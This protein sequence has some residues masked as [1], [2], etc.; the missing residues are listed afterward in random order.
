M[1]FLVKYRFRRGGRSG[2]PIIGVSIEFIEALRPIFDCLADGVCIADMGGRLIYANAAAGRLLG[3]MAKA[4]EE[5]TICELL[6]GEIK[7]G[8]GPSADCPLRTAGQQD[9]VTFTGTYPPSNRALRIRCLRA[10]LPHTERHFI[11]I[12]DI[13]SEA[14]LKRLEED[15]RH[16]F[17]HDLRSPLTNVMG[18]L[19]VIEEDGAGYALSPH[20]LDMIRLAVRSCARITDLLDDYLTVARLEAGALPVRLGPTDVG[21]LVRGCADEEAAAAR[22]RSLGLESSAPEGLT[23][24][25]DEKLLRRVI[26]NLTDNALK[27]T[28]PGGN[29]RIGAGVDA[30]R[31]LVRVE[32]DGP[33]ISEADLPHIFERFYQAAGHGRDVGFGLGLTFC[34]QALRAMG[35]EISAQSTVGRGSAFTLKVPQMAVVGSGSAA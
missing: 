4:A 28:P 9:A 15:W 2:A 32:D 5:R 34:R 14:D 18:V 24:L 35:G 8:H 13:S 26:L 6:C 31:I 12:E 3:S 29:V 16:M 17:A 11:V 33:G 22:A 23:A 20:D 21:R 30:G 19:R 1:T 7:G 27:F 25:A 10:R